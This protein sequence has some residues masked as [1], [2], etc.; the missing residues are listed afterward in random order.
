VLEDGPVSI[1][2]ASADEAR[3]MGVR[4]IPE[5]VEGKLRLIEIHG[6][7]LNACGGTHVARTGQIG[8]I[9]LRKVEKVKQGVRVEFVCGARAVSAARKDFDTLT[10]AGALFSSHIYDVPG[11]IRKTIDEAKS[12]GK[13][14]FKLQE[15]LAEF[16]ADRMLRDASQRGGLR[17]VREHFKDRD[18]NSIKLLAQRIARQPNAVALLACD[19]PQPSLVFAQS[20][21]GSFDMGAWMKETMTAAGGRGGGTRDM[22]QGGAPAGADLDAALNAAFE[23]IPA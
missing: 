14:E 5:H 3:A 22:A 11:Q 1:R 18:L 7:D 19:L 6:H 16:I 13:R 4:K 20:T 10:S 15:E 9:L 21:G 2:F 23:R 12:A 8:A 17:V